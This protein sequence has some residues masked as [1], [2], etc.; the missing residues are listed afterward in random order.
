MP[1]RRPTQK[2]IAALAGVHYSVVCRALRN[3]PSIPVVTR[4]RVMKI[5][6]EIGYRPDPALS[7]LAA[8]RNSLRPRTFQGQLAWLSSSDPGRKWSQIDVFAEYMKSAAAEAKRHGYNLQDF[9]LDSPS[10]TPRRLA[11]IMKARNVNGILICPQPDHH[12]EI[13]LPWDHFS[14]ITLGHALQQ[15][16]LHVVS[17]DHYRSTRRIFQELRQLG[18]QRIGLAIPSDLDTR[19]GGDFLSA[20]LLEQH[21]RPPESQLAP[22]LD[23]STPSIDRFAAWLNQ[24]KPDA[25]M[26]TNY[27]FPDYLVKLGQRIPEDLGVA[28]L[29]KKIHGDDY[30]GIDQNAQRTAVVAMNILVSMVQHSERGAARLAQHI[31]VEGTWTEGWSVRRIGPPC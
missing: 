22:F 20:Y 31:K 19:V 28:I 29:F 15:P 8:Y 1:T 12:T 10:M 26:T 23:T 17:A 18:Y 27:Y 13:D 7:A 16:H 25:L 5:A 4:D 9:D 11:S 14:A 2:N 24:Y 30:A 21:T 3:H 6:E